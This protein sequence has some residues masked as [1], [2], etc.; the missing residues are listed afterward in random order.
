MNL[1]E[2]YDQKLDELQE[3]NELK[4]M[5]IFE[6]ERDVYKD[7]PKIRIDSIEEKVHFLAQVLHRLKGM[8]LEGITDA[9][10]DENDEQLNYP[11]I[12]TSEYEKVN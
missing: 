4:D 11:R 1:L 9:N 5:K 3:D 2:K 10:F 8:Y 7:K 12:P 6:Y